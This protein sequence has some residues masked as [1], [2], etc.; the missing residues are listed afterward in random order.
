MVADFGAI[1]SLKVHGKAKED[2]PVFKTRSGGE[3]HSVIVLG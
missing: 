2:A 3:A 1:Y